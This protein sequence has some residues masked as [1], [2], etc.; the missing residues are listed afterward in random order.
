MSMN[1]PGLQANLQSGTRSGS[2][3]TVSVDPRTD[4]IGFKT[5]ASSA[6]LSG[7]LI[8]SATARAA[9]GTGSAL[10]DRIVEFKTTSSGG[11]EQLSAAGGSFVIHH[12]GAPTRLS[13]TLSSFAADGAPL[14]ATLPAIPLAAGETL[15][16]SPSN[17][18]AIGTAPV[19]L[20]ATVGGRTSTTHVRGRAVGRRFATVGHAALSVAGTTERV[21][22]ALRVTRPPAGAWVSIGARILRGRQVVRQANP[23][24]VSGSALSKGLVQLALP[25][26]LPSG[27]YSLRIRL[28]ETVASGAVQGSVVVA[29]AATVKAP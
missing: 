20:T 1:L 22:V 21:N 17:W 26:R 15:R 12:E 23:V 14:E 25:S 16:A 6:A 10:G 29:S 3:D 18:G 28:L 5:G 13:L 2:N 9:A 7:T 4:S 8:S 27:R 24:Q 19:T 11:G